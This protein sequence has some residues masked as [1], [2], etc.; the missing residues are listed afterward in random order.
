MLRAD[1]HTCQKTGVEFI[2]GRLRLSTVLTLG[3]SSW[4]VAN[5]PAGTDEVT[6]R[7]SRRGEAVEVRY[8]TGTQ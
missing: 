3:W 2:E 7:A 5:L 6:L 8:T 1:E 4:I